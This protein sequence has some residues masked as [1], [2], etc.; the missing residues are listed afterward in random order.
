MPM[1]KDLEYNRSEEYQALPDEYLQRGGKIENTHKSSKIVRKKMIFTA[2]SVLLLA[3]IAELPNTVGSSDTPDV[4]EPV[5]SDQTDSTT[6]D[7]EPVISDQTDS[8]VPD[9][10]PNLSTG[11]QENQTDIQESQ[12]DT[13]PPLYPIEDITSFYTVYNDSYDLE[14]GTEKIIEQGIL[15]E[16]SLLQGMDYPLPEPEPVD[17]YRFLGWVLYYDTT[18]KPDPSMGMAGDALDSGNIC[19]VKPVDGSRDIE[20]HAA[21]QRDGESNWPSL[22]TLDANGGTIENESVMTYDA[23]MPMGS[24]GYVYLCAYPVPIREGY[25]FEGWYTAPDGAG[26]KET[27]LFGME[28]YEKNGDE[29]DFS[30]MKEITLYAGWAKN[31]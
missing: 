23:A 22:L 26:E 24:G 21:W 29:Y 10:E 27:R 7:T 6:P 5:I 16:S 4:S 11:E 31:R 18:L 8:T 9:M 19:Y 2:V 13:E 28:F 30:S 14:T 3:H 25:T 15:F 12:S 1:K 17:G 20:V